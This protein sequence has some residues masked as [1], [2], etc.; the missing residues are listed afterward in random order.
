MDKNK[1]ETE[2]DI[3]HI[4]FA[5]LKKWL[6]LAVATLLGAVLAFG[7]THFFTKPVYE[8]SAYLY[9]NTNAVSVGATKISL[10]DMNA[11]S[12][13]VDRYSVILQ[14]RL[15]LEK[16][17]EEADLS[18]S[19]E[20]LYRMVRVS[21]VNNTEIFSV[22]VQSSD[23]AEA[24]KIANTIVRV[25]PDRISSIIQGCSVSVVDMAVEPRT[26]T[27][28]SYP[29][30]IVIGMLLGFIFSAAFVVITDIFNDRIDSDEWITETFGEELPLLAACPDSND[31]SSHK[32]GRYG[33]YSNYGYG[34]YYSDSRDKDGE[35]S[36]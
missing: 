17:I 28:P 34:S 4:L 22:T 12:S 15:T 33:R 30:N 1:G 25:L 6:L 35:K 3:L 29:K 10:A 26:P 13:L 32:Y 16:V 14:R 2:I 27:S 7:Y 19:Y 24:C 23:P 20:Q 8:S 5:L 11:A 18:Y 31:T 36:E 9:V 21:P